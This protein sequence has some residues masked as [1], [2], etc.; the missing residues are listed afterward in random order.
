MK[1]LILGK[2]GQLGNSLIKNAE[3]ENHEV[4]STNKKELDITKIENDAKFDTILKNDQPDIVINT[5]AYTDVI[6]CESNQLQA[7]N[8]NCISVRNLAKKTYEYKI[9]FMTF[10]TNYVFNGKKLM[11]N[12]HDNANPLN[13]YGLSKYAGEC[14]ALTYNNNTIIIRTS[15]LY[16]LNSKSAKNGKGNFI[17]NRISESKTNKYLNI[18]C[19]NILNTTYTEDLSEAIL[20]LLKQPLELCNMNGIYHLINEDICTWY[21]FTEEIFK[22]MNIDT[23]LIPI[24]RNGKFKNVNIPIFSALENTR[25][26]KLKIELPNW[27]DA[28]RRYL[29][30][31]YPD[32]VY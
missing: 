25:S 23:E 1:L 9:P 24:N 18:D 3:L 11:S 8:V 12:E 6:G 5:T 4:I 29:E 32:G 10:S 16:G 26:K 14:A 17:D 21:E 22:I 19:L 28:L 15:G 30:T 2:D 31:K 20:K 7:Y 27:K 13:I